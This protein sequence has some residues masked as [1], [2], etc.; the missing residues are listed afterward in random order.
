M[1]YGPDSING[2]TAMVLLRYACQKEMVA[3]RHSRFT[4]KL[5]GQLINGYLSL[6][7]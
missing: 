4:K 7:Y 5:D 6:K 2:A 1:C 3:P